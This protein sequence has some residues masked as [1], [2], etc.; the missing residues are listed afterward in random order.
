MDIQK[1]ESRRWILPPTDILLLILFILLA[2]NSLSWADAGAPVLHLPIDC[3]IGTECYIQNY[4]DTDPS[5]DYHDYTCGFLTYNGHKGT[6]FRLLDLTMMKR[7]VKVLAAT[8]GIVRATRDGMPDISVKKTG[9]ASIK[10]R[11]A[12]NSVAIRHG[13]GWETQYSHLR[14]D[15]VLVR[16]GD[17]VQAGQAL[18]LVGLS[19]N[20][21]FPHLHFALR[22]HGKTID[23]FSGHTPDGCGLPLENSRWNPAITTH[24]SYISSGIL[25]AGFTNHMP[26]VKPLYERLEKKLS[27]PKNTEKIIFW[28]HVFGVQNGDVQQLK[29]IAPDGGILVT[30]KDVLKKNQAQRVTII[31]KRLNKDAWPMGDYKG[32]YILNRPEGGGLKS[33]INRSFDLEIIEATDIQ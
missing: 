22:H 4:V 17:H 29:I 33:V 25:A 28:V 30:K 21:E 3:R 10:G 20:T 26:T 1:K 24:L 15:S 16:A 18:G 31:G 19:G 9:N 7:G 12:G 32:I 23:P 5:P 13:N 8:A 2:M 11:E 14:G 6:D 27:L